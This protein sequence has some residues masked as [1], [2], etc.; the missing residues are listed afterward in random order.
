MFHWNKVKYRVDKPLAEMIGTLQKVNNLLEA[1]RD[2]LIESC[3]GDFEYRQRRQEQVQPIQS[4]QNQSDY[5]PAAANV[6]LHSP[7]R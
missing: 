7:N 3:P 6:Q 1:R 4:N 5:A 2:I